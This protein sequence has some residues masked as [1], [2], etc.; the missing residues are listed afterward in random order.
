MSTTKKNSKALVLTC[1]G[2]DMV[3]EERRLR[4]RRRR[5]RWQQQKQE[6]TVPCKADTAG[7]RVVGRGEGGGRKNGN[8]NLREY[9]RA[10]TEAVSV[11]L[12]PV[13]VMV[14]ASI[15]RFSVRRNAGV[16]MTAV[17]S[18]DGDEDDDPRRCCCCCYCISATDEVLSCVLSGGR[19]T[20][21]RVTYTSTRESVPREYRSRDNK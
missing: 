12:V 4:R 14:L 21:S 8:R 5:W 20:E 3:A 10:I 13:V 18:G 17:S 6:T 1:Y 7:G 9:Y 19:S 15:A 11:V 16:Q 2:A